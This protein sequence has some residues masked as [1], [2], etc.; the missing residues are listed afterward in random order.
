M[1]YTNLKMLCVTVFVAAIL[2]ALGPGAARPARTKPSSIVESISQNGSFFKRVVEKS[3]AIVLF[4]LFITLEIIWN[5]TGA[6]SDIGSLASDPAEDAR[7]H[8]VCATILKLWTDLRTLEHSQRVYLR[9]LELIVNAEESN[10]NET[11]AEIIAKIDKAYVED[12]VLGEQYVR[13][14][15]VTAR[16]MKIPLNH[17]HVEST[18]SW[19]ERDK[20]LQTDDLLGARMLLYKFHAEMH[21]TGDNNQLV[22]MM[23][24]VSKDE[25]LYAKV[26]SLFEKTLKEVGSSFGAKGTDDDAARQLF[27]N[28]RRNIANN[29]DL[30]LLFRDQIV[31]K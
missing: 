8:V 29:A 23:L 25:K 22:K 10:V 11:Y 19:Q 1:K 15:G 12:S 13:L 4:P 20:L 18:L 16:E 9:A 6:H 2:C 31:L 26:Q 24:A 14:K 28:L 3:V 21:N 27:R 5:S 30:K 7:I 17:S